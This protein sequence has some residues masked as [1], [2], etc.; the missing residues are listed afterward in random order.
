MYV[1]TEMIG[2]TA[3]E[4]RYQAKKEKKKNPCRELLVLVQVF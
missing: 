2:I 1:R 3:G 4:A